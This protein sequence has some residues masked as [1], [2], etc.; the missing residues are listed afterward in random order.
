VRPTARFNKKGFTL[1]EVLVAL[2]V[3]M[4]AML[5]VLDAMTIAMQKNLETFFRDES[6]RIAE[7]AMNEARNA[8]FATLASGTSNVTRTYKQY[9]KTFTVNRT[10]TPLST[11]SCSIQ[12]RVS[13]AVNNKA[14]NHDVT[15]IISAG[16]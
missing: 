10:I 14:Y 5:A 3:L 1:V 8:S 16:I 6:V 13:W 9:A 7:Q 12:L 15:S 2:V 11:N 4:I